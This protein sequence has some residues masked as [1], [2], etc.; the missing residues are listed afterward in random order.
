MEAQSVAGRHGGRSKISDSSGTVVRVPPHSIDAEQS[1]LGG[2]MLD[3]SAWDD[4]SDIVSVHDFYRQDHRLVYSVMTKLA[5]QEKPIDV[6]TVSEA[7]REIQELDN[8]GGDVYLLG[9]ANN[10]PSVANIRA[11]AEIVRERSVLR[12]LIAV[13]S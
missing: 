11:Y 5:G 10:T 9:L 4:V 7:L 13:T 8:A 6:L 12:Q 1:V 2:L 3:N